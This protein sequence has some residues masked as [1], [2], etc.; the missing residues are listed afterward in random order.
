MLHTYL[1]AIVLVIGALSHSWL[2]CTDYVDEISSNDYEVG[3]CH[4]FM[5]SW[6]NVKGNTGF[7][8]DHGMNYQPGSGRACRDD[9]FEWSYDDEFPEAVYSVGDSVQ[10]LWPGKNHD[11]EE[12]TNPYIPSTRTELYVTCDFEN[13][14]TL[15]DYFGVADLV[16]DWGADGFQ[17]CPFFCDNTDKAICYQQF[18]VP[19]VACGRPTFLW[20]WAFNSESDVYTACFEATIGGSSPS[21][22]PTPAIG[23]SSTPA[24][25]VAPSPSPDGCGCSAYRLYTQCAGLTYK[26]DTC[27]PVGTECNY[28]NEYYSQCS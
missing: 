21:P 26:G 12:C 16:V 17:N 10:L 15:D 3:D 5:R 14:M 6:T 4:G 13:G 23:P 2:E 18:L 27:C 25:V 20:Y 22:V 28:V 1:H 19:S 24:P 8:V 9:L 7:G 11:A